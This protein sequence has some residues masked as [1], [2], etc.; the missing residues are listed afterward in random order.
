MINKYKKHNLEAK[1]CQVMVV[2][3]MLII[4]KGI[5]LGA[6]LVGCL[7]ATRYNLLKVT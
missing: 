2:N 6:L 5:T 3:S 4:T 7:I 1:T